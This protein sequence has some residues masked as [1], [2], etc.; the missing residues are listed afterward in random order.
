MSKKIIIKRREVEDVLDQHEELFVL[1][2]E[3]DINISVVLD[4]FLSDFNA[5]VESESTNN[6]LS[7]PFRTH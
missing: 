7:S 1:M 6:A 4:S 3:L 2:Q 5:F